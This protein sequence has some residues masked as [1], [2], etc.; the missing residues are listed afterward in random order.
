MPEGEPAGAAQTSELS[1]VIQEDATS[2]C[3]SVGLGQTFGL[4][5]VKNHYK[6]NGEKVS[7]AASRRS[8]ARAL[9]PGNSKRYEQSRGRGTSE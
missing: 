6:A 9:F 4:V 3:V 5:G 7:R 2:A 8:A 1:A